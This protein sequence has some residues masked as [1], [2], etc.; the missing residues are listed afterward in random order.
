MRYNEMTANQKTPETK[1]LLIFDLDGT[2]VDSREDLAAGVNLT[3]ADFRLPPLPVDVVAKFVGDGVRKLLERAFNGHDIDIDDAIRRMA[4]HYGERLHDKTSLYPGVAAGL[5]R[6]HEHGCKLALISNKPAAP[7]R[8]LL[9]HFN[10]LGLFASVMGGD[11]SANL[12]PHPDPVL[13]TMR[14]TNAAPAQTWMIGD[15]HTDIEA[16]ERAGVKSIF[17]TYGIGDLRGAATAMTC[18]SFDE[19]VRHF[20]PDKGM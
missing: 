8:E 20:I 1:P 6:L 12:K 4:R 14:R 10:I 3:R 16:A 7:C 18:D 19:I 17:V 11:S 5:A 15:N 13:E 9:R 2:L